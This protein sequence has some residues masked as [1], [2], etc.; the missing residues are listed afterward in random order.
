MQALEARFPGSAVS[1]DTERSAESPEEML[2][3]F[4]QRLADCSAL[5]FRVALGVLHN[6]EDAE[7]VAQEAFVRAYRS[8][9]TLRDRERFR[10]WL[11]RIAWRLALD[12]RRAA[13]RRERHELA[14]AEAM[15]APTVEDLAASRE[16]QQHVERAMDELPEKLRLVLIL[17]AVEGYDYGEVARVLG[18]PDGT[19]K[20]RLHVARKK[21]SERLQ[22][23]A[24][25]TKKA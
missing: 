8:F 24:S 3:E 4:E 23:F 10:G 12:R 21:L 6:R 11:A 15:P 19:V 25:A 9:H 16:F 1:L 17:A 18:L 5:A 13:G 20:S 14:A 22:C 7:D 2:R